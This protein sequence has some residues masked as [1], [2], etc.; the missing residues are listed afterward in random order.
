MHAMH[1]GMVGNTAVQEGDEATENLVMA[2]LD[3]QSSG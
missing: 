3:L 1:S 2:L